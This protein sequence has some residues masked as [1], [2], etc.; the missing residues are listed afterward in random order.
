[1]NQSAN[2]TLRAIQSHFHDV[3]RERTADLIDKH[4]LTLPDLTQLL[5]SE[6]TKAWFPI[7]GMCGGFSYWLEGEG[8]N[9]RLIA[10]SWCRVVSGSGQRHEITATGSRLVDE[11]FV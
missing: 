1:M 11:G 6:E 7:P 5:S 9:I 3:I 8:G 4:K 10:E 2:E